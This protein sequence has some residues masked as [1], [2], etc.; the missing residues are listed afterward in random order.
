MNKVGRFANKDIFVLF[1]NAPTQT[2]SVQFFFKKNGPFPA[3]FSLFSSFQYTVDSK[4]MFDI[5]KFLPMTG[6]KLRTSGIGSDRSTNWAT[7]TKCPILSADHALS[8]CILWSRPL[9]VSC[10]ESQEGTYFLNSCEFE[11]CFPVRTNENKWKRGWKTPIT[12][13]KRALKRTSN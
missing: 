8:T 1:K 9:V 7:T 6:F 12:I 5:N 2:Q 10:L 4:Q 13:L 11:S 3:S